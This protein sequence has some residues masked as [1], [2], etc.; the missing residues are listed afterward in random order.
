MAQGFSIGMQRAFGHFGGTRVQ[1][2]P[3]CPRIQRRFE[4]V[5]QGLRRGFVQTADDAA[6]A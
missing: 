2:F 3:I 5:Q 1:V 6:F 4:G